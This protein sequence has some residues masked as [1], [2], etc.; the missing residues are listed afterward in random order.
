MSIF[1][2][3]NEYSDQL[4]LNRFICYQAQL[5][6]LVILLGVLMVVQVLQAHCDI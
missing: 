6:L 2:H 1:L 4:I 5:L 3:N